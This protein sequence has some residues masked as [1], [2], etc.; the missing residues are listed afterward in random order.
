MKTGLHS[1]SN[2]PIQQITLYI[3]FKFVIISSMQC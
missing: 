3:S 1:T 2:N